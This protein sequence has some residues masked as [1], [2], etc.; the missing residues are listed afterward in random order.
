MLSPGVYLLQLH[1]ALEGPRAWE[2]SLGHRLSFSHA[3][4]VWQQ[5]LGFSQH[6]LAWMPRPRQLLVTRGDAFESDSPRLTLFS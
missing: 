5:K 4:G 3:A 2:T 6:P 1:S